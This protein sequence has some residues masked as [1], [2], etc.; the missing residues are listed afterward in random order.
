MKWFETWFDSKYYHILYKNRDYLEAT[1]FIDKILK[2]IKPEKKSF[3]LDLACGLGRHSIYLNKKGFYVDGMDISKKSLEKAKLNENKKLKFYLKDMRE[4]DVENK[5]NFVLNLFTSFGY[6]Q[7]DKD[8]KK[9]FINVNRSLKKNGFFIIDFLNAEKI[10]S[11][12]KTYEVK[13]I[14]NILFKIEKK[15][16]NKFVY[17]KISITDR[18]N[19]Y[20]FTEKVRLINK[21]KF[22]SYLNDLDIALVD[23]FGDYNLNNYNVESERLIL[24]FKKINN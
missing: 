3:F 24:L 19:K 13:K 10:I 22:I 11:K 15:H 5:Y 18:K 2:K 16:N 9:I 4:L 7:N 23:T 1:R 17:K 12:P 14:N 6:F 21:Q 20:T 8:N